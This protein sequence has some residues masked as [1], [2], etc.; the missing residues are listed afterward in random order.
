MTY[1][2]HAG[3]A[4]N[5]LAR[6]QGLAIDPVRL[7]GALAR[8]DGL[9][10]LA[11]AQ[12]LCAALNLLAVRPLS[13]PDPAL[14]PALA[15]LNSGEFGL[16]MAKQA[17]GLWLVQQAGGQLLLPDVALQQLLYLDPPANAVDD[18]AD[19]TFADQLRMALRPF[20]PVMVE[21]IIATLLIGL[22]TLATSMFSMQVYDRVIPTKSEYTLIVLGTGVLLIIALELMLKFSRS[23]LMDQVVIGVDSQL[24]RQI[25]ERLLAIRLD[26][27]PASV[28]SLAS[29][30]RGYEQIRNFYTASTLFGLADLPVALVFLLIIGSIGSIGVA[31]IP[32]LVAVLCLLLGFL[33]RRRINLLAR[34]GA[35]WTNRKTGLLVETVEGIETIKSGAG[36]FKLLSRWL[37]I[38][39]KTMRNDLDMRHANENINYL[40]ATLQQISYALM[41]MV[42][43][44]QVISGQMTM[45]ALIA[46]SILG[47]RVLT[48]IMAIPGLMVQQAHASAAQKGLESLYALA[49]DNQGVARPL[50]PSQLQGNYRFD[51]VQFAYGKTPPAIQIQQLDIRAGEHIGIL[52]PI[53][54]G[55]STLL[56]LLAGLYHPAEGRLLLD[57]LD[58][59]QISQA[60]L[61]QHIAYLQ[62]DH[63]LFQ[64][65]LRENLL[66]GLADPG[67]DALQQ[68]LNQSGLAQVVAAHP[69]G[70][71]LPISEGGK[72]LSGGQRQLVAFTRLLLSGGKILLLDEPTASMDEQQERR[73]L[74]VLAELCRRQQITLVVVTHKPSVLPLV[75]RLIIVAGHQIV[76]DGSKQAVLQQLSGAGPAPS[77]STPAAQDTSR[78]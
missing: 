67:D 41:V 7:Q 51:Q 61:S 35:E 19:Q 23:K 71:D 3:W 70:L 20:R 39:R 60:T 22:L 34:Q 56:R 40:A 64:G 45:G 66:I 57:G 24:S 36:G 28:G 31:L 69:L 16:L 72:G 62:Q 21:G 37:D 2:H 10:G 76:M 30:M 1:T 73:C 11:Q 5:S 33:A 75:D 43:S 8:V 46:C 15:V 65:T 63:R 77:S 9:T 78:P 44:Y 18:D 59:A 48:P 54:S 14:L 6:I 12:A 38:T 68:A 32:L 42:G 49:Q 13:Q 4:V 74:T 26:R 17:N 29:Q 53:G 27:L 50:T 58:M 55:K 52:G 47:G 25:Y